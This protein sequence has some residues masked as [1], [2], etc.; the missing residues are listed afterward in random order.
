MADPIKAFLAQQ[1]RLGYEGREKSIAEL[2]ALHAKA[3]VAFD[4]AIARGDEKRTRDERKEEALN[5]KECIHAFQRILGTGVRMPKM[6]LLALF[7]EHDKDKTGKIDFRMFVKIINAT[8]DYMTSTPN[9]MQ[10][11]TDAEELAEKKRKEAQQAKNKTE[12]ADVYAILG[13]KKSKDLQEAEKRKSVA[14][15][16]AAE[17]ARARLKA[18]GRAV[19]AKQMAV[20]RF[21]GAGM[22]GASKRAVTLQRE[23]EDPI[24]PTTK[25]RQSW[26]KSEGGIGNCRLRK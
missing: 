15:D 6:K 24:S 22:L 3:A 4:Q 2:R 21:A 26:S 5:E 19:L 11:E 18:A 25:N 20:K 8:T 17:V 10:E 7:L 16:N 13:I 9:W 14:L 12:A 1:N 23:E